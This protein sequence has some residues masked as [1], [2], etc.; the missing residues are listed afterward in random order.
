MQIEDAIISATPY[1]GAVKAAG[2]IARNQRGLG[3]IGRA[4]L[5]D[6]RYDAKEEAIEIVKKE[7]V[8]Y[9][10]QKALHAASELTKRIKK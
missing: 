4:A 10:E 9:A 8:G 3:R 6:E 1:G 5:G 7:A 2:F